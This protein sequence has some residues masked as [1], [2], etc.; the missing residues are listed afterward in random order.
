MAGPSPFAPF[1]GE[2]EGASAR[3]RIPFRSIIPNLITL[4][5]ICAGMTGV[6]LAFEGRFEIAVAMVLGAAALD[7]IDGRIA[8]LLKGQSRFGAEMDSLAD[9]VNFG[10]A[11]G[12]LLYAHTLKEAG[13]LGWIAALLYATACALRLARFNTMLDDPHQPKWHTG[14]FV[15]VPAPAGAGLAMLPMYLSFMGVDLGYYPATA[16][17]SALYIVFIGL[18]MVSRLPTFSGK[19]VGI[20]LRRDVVVPLILL[21]VLYVALLMS[22]LW[23]TLAATAVAYFISIVFSVRSYRE[24]ARREREHEHEHGY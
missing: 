14:Y 11:P 23:Q 15:G 4:L 22:F 8:R 19:S 6:R 3:R 13:S 1:D 21:V 2:D 12:L 18:L 24:R 20:R 16:T 7:G 9:I 5:A 17:L 10:I